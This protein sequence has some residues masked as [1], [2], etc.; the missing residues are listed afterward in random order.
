MYRISHPNGAPQSFSRHRVDAT[1]PTCGGWPRG[2]RIYSRDVI[3]ATQAGSSG[4]PVVNAAG[5]IVGQLSGTCGSNV[6]DDCDAV[7]NA[8]V[9]GAFA[10]Y[11]DQ[12]APYQNPPVPAEICD[13]AIDNDADT[14]I[15]CADPDCGA[16]PSCT[17][18]KPAGASCAS[19]SECCSSS[20]K[21]PAS[22]RTCR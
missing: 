9:D 14:L 13:D 17:P 21:G 8:T 3:G 12:V 4:A 7:S 2:A 11:Y 20:C 15:D 19:N 5:E 6:N 1:V 10:S 18:C 22:G 16:F